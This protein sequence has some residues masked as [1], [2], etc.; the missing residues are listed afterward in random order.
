MEK[1]LFIQWVERFFKGVVIS[2]VKKLNEKNQETQRYRFKEMLKKEFSIDG[3][4][5]SIV[6]EYTNIAADIV[7]MDS[8][9]PLKKR[10]SLYKASGDIPKSGMKL[11]LTEKQLKALDVLVATKATDNEIATKLFEDLS[12]NIMGIY[13]RMELTFLRGLSDGVTL[14]DDVDNDGVPIRV[15]YKYRTDHIF[16]VAVKWDNPATATPVDDIERLLDK[17]AADGNVPKIVLISRKKLKQ[18]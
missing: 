2:V 17:A 8:T 12:R 6:G 9:L 3:K 16:G 14:A 13:E 1:S 15:D 10:D 11:Y 4:W 7:S 18:L 5:E